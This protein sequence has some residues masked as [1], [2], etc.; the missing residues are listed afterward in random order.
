[1]TIHISSKHFLSVGDKVTV[2]SDDLIASDAALAHKLGLTSWKPGIFP[3]VKKVD[4]SESSPFDIAPK[5]HKFDQSLTRVGVV[6]KVFGDDERSTVV[7]V[8][9]GR[10]F[11][12]RAMYCRKN[13][14]RKPRSTKTDLHAA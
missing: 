10:E 7:F 9:K 14:P 13:P 2:M 6:T 5:K 1:M 11:M 4:N 12:T 3:K 8:V